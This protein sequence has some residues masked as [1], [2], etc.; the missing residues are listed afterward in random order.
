MGRIFG[1]PIMA[2]VRE[3][4]RPSRSIGR[5][6]PM[7]IVN[8]CPHLTTKPEDLKKIFFRPEHDG[9]FFLVVEMCFDCWTK[10]VVTMGTTGV[11]P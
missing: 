2:S 4:G 3:A 7:K 11:S 6:G 9:R 1:W 5:R 10:V 8:I